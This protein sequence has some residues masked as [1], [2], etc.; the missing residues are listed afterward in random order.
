MKYT[1][2]VAIV[3]RNVEEYDLSECLYFGALEKL[4]QVQEN[5]NLLDD[6]RH[7][8]RVIKLFLV[9]WGNMSRVVGRKG[10]K[11]KELGERLRNLEKEFSEL[12]NKKFLTIDFNNAVVANPIKTIY[13]K[14]D[15]LP[16]LGSPTT[17][18]KVLHLLNPEIF[19]M[20]DN[21]IERKYHKRNHYVKY[22]PEG[23]LEFLKESQKEIKEAFHD[24]QEETRQE[25]DEIEA[26]VRKRYGNRTLARI[27]D[28]Y[29]WMICHN[30]EMKKPV[31]VF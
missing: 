14:L 31:S 10:L 16:Y 7:V 17:I 27:V 22:T 5:L 3:D 20:W 11:W 21:E 28:Q 23:Y 15:N 13:A 6:I 26:S 12:R 4:K 19:V 29:N 9:S 30:A 1:E 2:L 8:Q 25:L 24:C 18:S